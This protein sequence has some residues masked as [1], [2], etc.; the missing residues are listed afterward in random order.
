MRW[1]LFVLVRVRLVHGRTARRVFSQIPSIRDPPSPRP[2]VSTARILANTG[3]GAVSE[4][5]TWQMC[6]AGFTSEDTQRLPARLS[7]RGQ[8]GARRVR[9]VQ[10][11]EGAEA[12]RTPRAGRAQHG[13]GPYIY[14][15]M[16]CRPAQPGHL[17]RGRKDQGEHAA[18]QWWYFQVWGCFSFEQKMSCAEIRYHSGHLSVLFLPGHIFKYTCTWDR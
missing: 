5:N 9:R 4:R 3:G 15:H 8:S 12:A 1:C 18:G 16:Q 11:L 7:E 14:T 10:T 2:R 6:D 17:V 13:V